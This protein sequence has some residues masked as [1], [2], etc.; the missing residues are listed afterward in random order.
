MKPLFF[1][2]API[3]LLLARFTHPHVPLFVTYALIAAAI[4]CVV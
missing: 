1:I 4:A 3:L 2:I